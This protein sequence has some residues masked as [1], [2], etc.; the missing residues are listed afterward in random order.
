M[1]IIKKTAWCRLFIISF[2][3]V[4]LLSF[5]AESAEENKYDILEIDNTQDKYD[6]SPYLEILEDKDGKLTINDIRKKNI[7]NKFKKNSVK[8]PNFAYTSSA[9]WVK[10]KVRFNK[11]AKNRHIIELAYP[12]MDHVE[13]YSPLKINRYERKKY[14]DDVPFSDR[15][16]KHRHYLF[17]LENHQDV[18]T[19]YFRFK[20]TGTFRIILNISPLLSF[21]DQDFTNHYILGIYYGIFLVMFIIYLLI[22]ISFRDIS[23]LYF[24]LFIAA[25][26]IF[27]SIE[28]GLLF[29]ILQP[30]S[31]PWKY[32]L[33][34]LFGILSL[35]TSLR[36]AQHF[37]FLK[38]NSPFFNNLLNFLMGAGI[39]LL[40]FSTL[41]SGKYLAEIQLFAAYAIISV[42]IFPIVGIVMLIRGY[43]P[44]AL[45]MTAWILF[46]IGVGIFALQS[47]AIIESTTLTIYI[48]QITSISVVT[49]LSVGMVDRINLMQ[50]EKEVAQSQAL[51]NEKITRQTQE[52]MIEHLHEMAILK[53]QFLANTSHELR[54]PLN[55]IIGIAESLSDGIC[56]PLKEDVKY[57]LSMIITSGKRLL[58]L[59]ND[60]L[61]FTKLKNKD[62]TL[63]KEPMDIK[64]IT[65]VIIELT[66]P[67]ANGKNLQ[68]INQISEDTPLVLA[69]ENRIYQV[70]MNLISN[71]IKFTETG[72]I[73]I[74]ARKNLL[75]TSLNERIQIGIED[76]GIGIDKDVQDKIFEAFEQADGSISKK[77]HGSGLGLSITKK[78]IE[79]HD[80]IISVESTPGEGATFKFSLP[81]ADEQE[82]THD[83]KLPSF[84]E[85]DSVAE[86]EDKDYK[87]SNLITASIKSPDPGSL[88]IMIIDDDRINLQVL[89]NYLT[90]RKYTVYKMQNGPEALEAIYSGT[91]PDLILLDIMMPQ[92]SGYEVLEKLRE[93]YPSFKMPVILLSAKNQIQDIV[94]GLEKGAN[95]YLQKPFDKNELFARV[96]T[97]LTLKLAVEDKEKFIL[98]KEQMSL[99]RDIQFSTL[100]QSVPELTKIGISS[101]YLPMESVGGDFYDFYI[102]DEK[103]IGIFISDVSGHGIPAA[104]I[105]SM[106]KIVFSIYSE[107]SGSPC[108]LLTAMNKTLFGNI[109]ERFITAGYIEIDQESN[110]AIFARAG[111]EP[112]LHYKKENNSIEELLPKGG[113]IGIIA[114]MKITEVPLELES[115]DKIILYSDGITEAINRGKEFYELDRLKSHIVENSDLNHKLL[116]E[117]IISDLK[118]WT[119]GEDFQDDLTLIVVDIL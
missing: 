109:E 114:D 4:F 21:I 115:G 74:W 3:A 112:L 28:N 79:L 75:K 51:E 86:I 18:R 56:G 105:A 70:M 72:T 84:L 62:I 55:G 45:F 89:D 20:T 43:R 42:I 99:A 113:A 32:K 104:L 108:E 53:D 38:N 15:E 91:V 5:N 25:Y 19:Y 39:T 6:L 13:L 59:V 11:N 63:N 117:S 106:M 65:D 81:I 61:D 102:P 100:P 2:L 52:K 1:N 41:T 69:D 27:Q 29:E 85:R 66:A 80:G 10:F 17:T 118:S 93:D 57:N 49:L 67:L 95:D 83:I 101:R 64:A 92:M 68:V 98:F 44:A 46:F 12:L 116:T 16:I 73:K 40:V 23:Y 103:S 33:Y 37:L 54:T 36:F 77:Y 24:T 76:T 90:S 60:I 8:I 30:D 71:A 97:L 82:Q 88:K 7:D 107:I 47:F 111:H 14:G 78:L 34:L 119:G 22:F 58:N 50:K 94:A 87:N 26:G 31:I 48:M 9:Y 96:N 110:K 35:L